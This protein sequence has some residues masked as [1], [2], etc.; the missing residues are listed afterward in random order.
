MCKVTKK[1]LQRIY[2]KIKKFNDCSNTTDPTLL[3]NYHRNGINTVRAIINR[4]APVNENDTLSYIEFVSKGL[5][6]GSDG[7]IICFYDFIWLCKLICQFESQVNVLPDY[8]IKVINK[9]LPYVKDYFA[10]TK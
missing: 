4:F 7:E 6:C 3:Y 10:T 1:N 8:L 2:D 5:S 9:H